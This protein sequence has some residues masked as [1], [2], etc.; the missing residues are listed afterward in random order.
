[1]DDN[2]TSGKMEKVENI[3]SPSLEQNKTKSENAKS[4]APHERVGLSESDRAIYRGEI[5]E[6]GAANYKHKEKESASYYLTLKQLDGESITLWGKGLPEA[7]PKESKKG[8][9]IGVERGERE[10]VIVKVKVK[11]ESG[12]EY[13]EDRE[14]LRQR[15]LQVNVDK[16]KDRADF[17]AQQARS[18]ANTDAPKNQQF[19]HSKAAVEEAERRSQGPSFDRVVPGTD[20]QNRYIMTAER[21]KNSYADRRKPDVKLVEDRGS[22]LKA[23]EV[24]PESI[25]LVVKLAKEKDWSKISVSGTKDFKRQMWMEASK[26]GIEVKGYTP[27]KEEVKALEKYMESNRNKENIVKPI[28][29]DS[30]QFASEKIKSPKDQERFTEAVKV[31]ANETVEKEGVPT[32]KDKP[33]DQAPKQAEPERKEK[34]KEIE[35]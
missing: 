14:A 15:W 25:E 29:E 6:H 2:K 19:V 4:E 21:T 22:D 1:M 17:Q 23:K 3:V 18:E 8:D 33:R 7:I 12:K 20:I 35:R 26:E 16:E 30:K 24:T 10:P 31:K 32:L 5:V 34:A 9:Y 27:S 28:I 11:D 13:S